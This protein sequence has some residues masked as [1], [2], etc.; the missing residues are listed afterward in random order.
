M[1]VLDSILVEIDN[2]VQNANSTKELVLDRLLKDGIITQEIYN[3]Y[4]ENWQ[5]III[6]NNWFKR[7]TE[8]FSKTKGAYSYKYLKF[9]D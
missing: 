5:V 2:Y 8:K 1:A 7:W 3:T 4:T 6:K 9:E